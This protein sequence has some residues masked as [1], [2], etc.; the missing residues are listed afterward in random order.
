MTVKR[1]NF[2]Q[3]QKL[4]REQANVEVHPDGD[5]RPAI[6]EARLKFDTLRGV[7]DNAR[8][9]VEAYHQTTRMRFDYGTVA[10][11]AEPP[12]EARRLHEFADWKDVL[13]RVKVTDV[14]DRPGR[15]VAWAN[16][17]RPKGPD[18]RDEPD[19]VR[20]KDA[21]LYGRLWDM[22]YDDSGPIVLIER[23]R[24][25]QTIGRDPAFRAAVYPE[26]MRRALEYAFIELQ[27]PYPQ[28]DHWS[29]TWVDGFVKPKLGLKAPPSF[30]AEGEG[31]LRDW[32]K[33]AVDTFARKHQLVNEWPGD[34]EPLTEDN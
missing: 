33:E 9:F 30:D 12:V 2:T 25:A 23:R 16:Q 8:V 7:A 15:L 17:I 4:T 1:M 28:P 27:T 32:I 29:T 5:G 22:D 24:N 6:F 21:D 10:A 19:L 18:D 13:F 3:R 11:L 31:K 26:I 14:I 34:P 20:F